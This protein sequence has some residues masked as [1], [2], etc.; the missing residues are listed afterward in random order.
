MTLEKQNFYTKSKMRKRGDG[1]RRKGG[2]G[3]GRELEREM[4]GVWMF[5]FR[6]WRG[7]NL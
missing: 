3:G 5:C 6:S 4:R 1:G 7:L 2:E